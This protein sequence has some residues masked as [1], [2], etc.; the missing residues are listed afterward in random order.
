MPGRGVEKDRFETPH[1]SKLT[2]L[3]SCLLRL[4]PVD[5]LVMTCMSVNQ[6]SLGCRSNPCIAPA[7]WFLL[8]CAGAEFMQRME[9]SRRRIHLGKLYARRLIVANLRINSCIVTPELDARL[10]ESCLN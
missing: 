9:G 2:K 8:C 10:F 6:C 7:V 3:L 4:S 5:E 1:R